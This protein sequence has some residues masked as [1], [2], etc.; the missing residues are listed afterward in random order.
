LHS[1]PFHTPHSVSSILRRK[2]PWVFLSLSIICFGTAW[3]FVW[4][5]YFNPHRLDFTHQPAQITSKFTVL[6]I[7]LVIADLNI[8]LPVIPSQI[9]NGAWMTT[10]AGVSYLTASAR[11]GQPGNSI[12]YGH[13]WPVI[14]GNLLQAK[15][16]QDILVYNSDG[17]QKLFKIQLIKEVK[18]DDTSILLSTFKPVL[19]IYTCSGFL[20][21]RRFVVVAGF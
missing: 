21:S 15:V 9:I 10:P 19:T 20:D 1:L 3:F 8:D 13:N 17:S 4:Q 12:F 14:L 2:L 16:G 18:P 5:R 11:P 6:P 7:R